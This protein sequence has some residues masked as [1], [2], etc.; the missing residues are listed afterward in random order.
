MSA[1]I[2][3]F[4]IE[5][6]PILASVWGIWQ[7]NIPTARIIEDWYMLTWSGKWLGEEEVYYDSNHLH[8]DHTCDKAALSSLHGFLDEADIVVGH[9]GNRFDIPKVNAR[10]IQQGMSPP[11]P[12]RKIDTLREARKNFKFTSNRL[13]ALGETL[14]LGRKAET[15]GFDLWKGCM[16][17]DKASFEAMIDYNI[18]DVNLLERVYLT[19]RPWMTTHPNLGVYEEEEVPSCPKC[20]ST[21]IHYRGKQYTQV[22]VYNRFQCQDCGGWGRSRTTENTL[23]KRKS[24]TNNAGH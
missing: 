8:G 6:A 23:T 22:A 14:G 5:T 19:L 12:Y 18:Q 15:G 16:A 21:N 13:D 1:K 7:E 4:D 11:S 2:F 20:T 9:N 3:L 17:G 10:F 24:L